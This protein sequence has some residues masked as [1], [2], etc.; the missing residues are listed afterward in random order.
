ME[1]LKLY[2]FF[3][4][5]A[6]IMIYIICFIPIIPRTK[7]Y[8]SRYLYLCIVVEPF[9]LYDMGECFYRLARLYEENKNS[10][11]DILFVGAFYDHHSWL[12]KRLRQQIDHS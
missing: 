11:E 5:K 3:D 8:I 1:A 2:T 9:M 12:V 10:N 7:Q 6:G 4:K